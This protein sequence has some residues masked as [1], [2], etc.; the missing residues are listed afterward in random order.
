MERLKQIVLQSEDDIVRRMFERACAQG[1][2]QRMPALE[3]SYRVEVGTLS[4]NFAQTLDLEGDVQS[5]SAA[6]D[7]RQDPVAAVGARLAR[8]RGAETPDA[9]LLL[10]LLKCYR[11][12][13][14]DV[15]SSSGL[16]REELHEAI[17]AI[18]RFF[19]RVEIGVVFERTAGSAGHNPA[20]TVDRRGTLVEERNRYL[21]AFSS[22]PL[23]ALFIDHD[24]HVEHI[25]A[26]ASLLFGPPNATSSRY[27]QD[28]ADREPPPVLAKEIDEF[29]EQP[30]AEKS[31]ERELKTGKGTRYFQV[32][33]TKTPAADGSFSGVLVVLN[34]L[35][36][37]RNA[38][39]ALR[40][41]QSQYA[42]LFEHM[43]IGFVHTR[44]LLDRRNRAADHTVLEVNPA[45][46]RLCGVSASSLIGHQFTEV[47][48]SAG[49]QGPKWM[50]VLGRTALTGETASFEAM[51]GSDEVRWASV[52]AFSPAQGHVA[53]MLLDITGVKAIEGSLA[54][55]RDS[56]LT[57][58]EGM[59]SLVW[60]AGRDGRVD[61]VNDMWIEFTGMSRISPESS[62]QEAVHP[63]DR[64]RRHEAL[65][66]AAREHS[67]L[68]L[69]YRLR[70]VDG[71][72]RWVQ[73]TARP[74]DGLDGTFAGLIGTT[75]DISD[76]RQR[77]ETLES[78][79]TSDPLTGLLTGKAFEEALT[80]SV[81]QVSRGERAVL[82]VA[83]LDGFREL[84]AVKGH[85]AGDA[86]LRRT[87]DVARSLVRSGDIIARVGADAFAVL[88]PS[89]NM[90]AGEAAARRLLEAVRALRDQE[91]GPLT[92]SVGL[93][94]V[95]GGIE[96]SA[97][98]RYAETAA[99]GA[100]TAGGDR[101]AVHDLSR[102]SLRVREVRGVASAVGAALATDDGLSLLYQPA[103]R[104]ADGSI[105]YSEALVRFRD[106]GGMLLEPDAF[107][108][109][110]ALAGLMPRLD[111]WVV[112]RAISDISR[113][114]GARLSINVS[115]EAL[116]SPSLLQDASSWAEEAGVAPGLVTFEISEDDALADLA[117]ARWFALEARGRGFG[118]ALDHVGRCTHSFGHL[119]E[120][121]VDR[122]TI[123]G[124]VV[125]SLLGDPRRLRLV[126]SVQTVAAALGMATVAQWVEDERT[127]AMVRDA[128]I[129]IVQG[130]HLAAP[131]DTVSA[132]KAADWAGK[133]PSATP[134][135]KG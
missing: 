53:L 58:L 124:G 4:A 14:L 109:D 86:A 49:A 132:A 99:R 92:V 115:A 30:E 98:L 67:A 135:R 48:R 72:Y 108:G 106:G 38:E 71:G 104:I 64:V 89:A 1:Y 120:L 107:L 51:I 28:P 16:T 85:D 22:L 97:I 82:L 100:R 123:D 12:T 59:P 41:S 37:R 42:A 54:R 18:G 122:V 47:L 63:D 78:M 96:P 134:K 44:V 119:Q 73:E 117:R 56:V 50:D 29:R 27:F 102:G 126:E 103:F 93:C 60:R 130:R 69:E 26:A 9:A 6:T 121:P 15:V 55:S 90:E 62:W 11:S 23:P 80:R 66:A 32:R 52:S 131:A 21:A 39:E 88:L 33:F 17:R 24:G 87:A 101:V 127:L 75:I 113:T 79:A 83:D 45:F 125:S 129:D 19:D 57:L 133:F 114:P 35:T 43:P 13:F 112:K 20:A 95:A 70:H 5:L 2:G 77:D 8:V 61:F 10:G 36:H 7:L 76:R 65:A 25:N 84:N 116:P 105:E 111:R 31:F 128:S 91:I 81:A 118:V 34:D 40:R 68:E 46:E 3:E 94:D 74:F 110:A